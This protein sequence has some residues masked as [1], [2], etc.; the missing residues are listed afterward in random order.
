MVEI[1][2]HNAIVVGS[3][4]A[5]PTSWC[6]WRSV[7]LGLRTELERDPGT[8]YIIHRV[9]MERGE[10]GCMDLGVRP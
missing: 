3:N 1:G 6:T 7:L 4:P 8:A 10:P 9:R 2:A 5:R